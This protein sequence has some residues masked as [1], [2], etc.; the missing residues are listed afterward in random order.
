MK[1]NL[2]IQ[3][4]VAYSKFKNTIIML[5]IIKSYK[6][7]NNNNKKHNKHKKIYKGI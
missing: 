2:V 1:K 5:I 3:Q 7:N 4:K 6:N